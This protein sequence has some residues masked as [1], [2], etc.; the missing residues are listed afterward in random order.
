MHMHMH[1]MI[2][3]PQ[4]YRLLEEIHHYQKDSYKLHVV[5][6]MQQYLLSHKLSTEDDLHSTSH[7]VEPR[8]I[9]RS[10]SSS[11][12]KSLSTLQSKSRFRGLSRS[13]S[14]S[15]SYLNRTSLS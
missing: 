10:H 7:T 8:S 6:E 11:S 2:V 5:P 14:S 12:T 3:I 15:G 4:V 1:M 13:G 9:R